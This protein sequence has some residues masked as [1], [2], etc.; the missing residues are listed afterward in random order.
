MTKE[1]HYFWAQGMSTWVILEVFHSHSLGNRGIYLIAINKV[2]N[3]VF[4]SEKTNLGLM[5]YHKNI[6]KW[7]QCWQAGHRR[8]KR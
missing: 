1:T 6:K 4:Y 3:N 2:S 7:G 5:M 8:R